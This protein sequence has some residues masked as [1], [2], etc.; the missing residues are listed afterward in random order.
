M[1]AQIVGYRA[2]AFEARNLAY[3]FLIAFG[4]PLLAFGPFMFGILKWP[5]TIGPGLAVVFTIVQ[6]SPLIAAFVMTRITGGKPG[7]QALW[8]RF[9]NRNLSIRWLLVVLLINP[10]IRLVASLIDRT[11]S[12]QT[13]PLLIPDVLPTFIGGLFMGIQEEFGWRG[14]VLPRFQAKWNALTSSLILGAIW[15]PYHLGKWILPPGDPRRTDNF[16]EFTVWIIC[17]S[18]LSTWIFNNTNGSVLAVVLF[19][20][21]TTNGLI[22]CCSVPWGMELIV[23]VTLLAAILIVAV[24][25]PKDLVRR[26]AEATASPRELQEVGV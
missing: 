11:L 19:H 1:N 22:D 2:K 25:G 6:F 7:V 20:A 23:G 26:R 4:L 16:W 24:F 17:L 9:W 18:I 5:A 10:V 15:A 21:A 8:R 14:Y 13:Y 12:G 3:F